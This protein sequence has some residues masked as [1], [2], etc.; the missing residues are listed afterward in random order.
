MYLYVCVCMCEYLCVYCAWSCAFGN[1]GMSRSRMYDG[2]KT[3]KSL[4]VYKC[5]D[6]LYV[7]VCNKYMYMYV[8]ASRCMYVYICAWAGAFG[9]IGVSMSGTY[10]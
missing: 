10:D 6:I 9:Y 5:L 4:C 1:I 2:S 3:S 7:Y 8:C